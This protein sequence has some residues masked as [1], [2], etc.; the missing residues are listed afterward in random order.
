[1]HSYSAHCTPGGS[2][3]GGFQAHVLQGKKV[4]LSCGS[5]IFDNTELNIL[6]HDPGYF[7]GLG[8]GGN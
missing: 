5:R 3:N 8:V 6:W 4:L 1:M 7:P 2:L